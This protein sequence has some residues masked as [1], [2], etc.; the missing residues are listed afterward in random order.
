MAMLYYTKNPSPNLMQSFIPLFI[1]TLV[2]FALFFVA[3]GIGYIVQK[4]P[5]KGSCGG[6][7]SLMGDENCQFCGGD[8]NKCDSTTN[9]ASR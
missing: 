9:K 3:L 7:A 8:P 5:L 6:V 1:A 2:V 4:K